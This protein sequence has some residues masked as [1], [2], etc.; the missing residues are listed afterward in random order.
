[1][2]YKEPYSG[3]ELMSPC[4]LPTTI[5]IMTKVPPI[6]PTQ[7]FFSPPSYLLLL[8][9]AILHIK[10]HQFTKIAHSLFRN[11]LSNRNSCY[12]TRLKR[13]KKKGHFN[14]KLEQYLPN[15]E[16]S[17]SVVLF[18]CFLAKIL[19]IFYDC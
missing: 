2:K 15:L 3:F 7:S 5:T 4:P 10:T 18:L 19:T 1:M 8:M 6:F 16:F 13:K 9:I 11:T 12:S 14:L 17:P